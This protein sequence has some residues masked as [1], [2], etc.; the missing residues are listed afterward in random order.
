MYK[1]QGKNAI[2]RYKNAYLGRNL[3]RHNFLT[4]QYHDVIFILRRN[5]I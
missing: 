1:N 2:S 4:F 5:T 3:P